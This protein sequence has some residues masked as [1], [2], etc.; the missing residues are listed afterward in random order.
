M[1]AVKGTSIQTVASEPVA[2]VRQN[3][4]EGE[5]CVRKKDEAIGILL[6]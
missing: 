1:I 2:E 3:N 4:R 5:G 6:H